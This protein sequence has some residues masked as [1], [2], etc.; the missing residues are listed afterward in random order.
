M[1]SMHLNCIDVNLPFRMFFQFIENRSFAIFKDQMQLSFSSKYFDQ[2]DQIW[3]LQIL[4]HANFTKCNFFDKRV[5]FR[6]LKFLD[7]H[8]L[9]CNKSGT[10]SNSKVKSWFQQFTIVLKQFPRKLIFLRSHNYYQVLENK[11]KKYSRE[12]RI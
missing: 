6:L 4:Q 9:A 3:M 10:V 7:G 2:I 8:K 11:R 5:L 1:E 12:E